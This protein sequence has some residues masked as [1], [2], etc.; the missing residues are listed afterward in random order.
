L[1]TKICSFWITDNKIFFSVEI[2]SLFYY[3]SLSAFDIKDFLGKVKNKAGDVEKI[4]KEKDKHGG[5]CCR[6]YLFFS[7]LLNFVD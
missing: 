4:L 1:Y 5:L 7:M 3:L 6:F 2:F